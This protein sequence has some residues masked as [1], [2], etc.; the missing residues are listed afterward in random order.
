MLRPRQDNIFKEGRI[1]A[2][3]GH[4]GGSENSAIFHMCAKQSRLQVNRE[5]APVLIDFE[6]SRSPF[7][8]LGEEDSKSL[9]KHQGIKNG[10]TIGENVIKDPQNGL[11]GYDE[12][13]NNPEYFEVSIILTQNRFGSV[14]I[15]GCF[16]RMYTGSDTSS[17][18]T[19][20]C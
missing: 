11:E 18:K 7:E 6:Y 1:I 19:G 3:L 10:V 12:Y 13:W 2:A 4:H 14:Y 20:S 17:L 5:N 15:C 16:S 8:M 9:P